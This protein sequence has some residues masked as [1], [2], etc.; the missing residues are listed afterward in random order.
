[1]FDDCNAG[2]EVCEIVL[3]S[4]KKN[5]QISVDLWSLDTWIEAMEDE[6]KIAPNESIDMLYVDAEGHDPDVLEGASRT[7]KRVGL[8][9]FEYSHRSVWARSALKTIVQ[10][11]NVN[12]M[13]CYLWSGR[14]RVWRLT[15]CWWDDKFEFHWPSNAA[16]VKRGTAWWH[17]FE[18]WA[19]VDP[20]ALGIGSTVKKGRS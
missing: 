13:D 18:S 11:F 6:G 1:M 19:V 10:D 9:F 12:G 14:P 5:K 17:L 7:L 3:S 8:V 20:A 4:T 16:C 2:D 15:G